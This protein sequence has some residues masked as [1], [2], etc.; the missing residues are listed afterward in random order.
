MN[1]LKVL[2]PLACIVA[3]MPML[4]RSSREEGLYGVMVMVAVS[5][6]VMVAGM[7]IGVLFSRIRRRKKDKNG[8]D[9]R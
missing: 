5:M 4:L 1:R 2:V 9:V 7:L 3:L 6:G 8:R